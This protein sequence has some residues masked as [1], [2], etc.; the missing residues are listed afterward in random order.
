MEK[1]EFDQPQSA[2]SWPRFL[3]GAS[4]LFV[5]LFTFINPEPSQN[6]EPIARLLFW[7]AHVALPIGLMQLAQ[8]GV[9]HFQRTMNAS[10]WLQVTIAGLIGAFMFLPLA[11][12]LDGLFGL[13]QI[14]ISPTAGLFQ[15]AADEYLALAPAFTVVWLG[16]NAMRVWRLSPTAQESTLSQGSS[17]QVSDSGMTPSDVPIQAAQIELPFMA[18]VPRYL[19][20]EIVKLSA[21]LHYL[22]VTT[23][24]GETSI[25]YAFGQAVEE[26]S[27]TGLGI[28]IHRSHWVARAHVASLRRDDGKMVCVLLSGEAIPVGRARQAEVAAEF[29]KN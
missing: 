4:V 24:V 5:A 10:P 9:S 22:R 27:R 19:G 25:L 28:Q 26:L 6:L 7:I 23:T 8:S 15:E 14:T 18:R 21:E 1:L 20:K 29:Q 16:L 2:I 11:I 13:E 12:L 3:A 17:S